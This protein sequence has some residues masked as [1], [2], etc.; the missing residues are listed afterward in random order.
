MFAYVFKIITN[1]MCTGKDLALLSTA[2][3]RL[4]KPNLN[5]GNLLSNASL[6][7]FSQFCLGIVLTG[8]NFADGTMGLAWPASATNSGGFCETRQFSPTYNQY[9]SFNS[10]I[11]TV[12]SYNTRVINPISQITLAHEVGH[13]FGS[14]H[15]TT[16][17]CAPGDSNGG[18]YIMYYAAVTSAEPN[19]RNFSQCSKDTMGP[20]MFLLASQPKFCF[21]TPNSTTCGNMIVE[22]GEQCDCGFTTDCTDKCCYPADYVDPTKRCKLTPSSKCRYIQ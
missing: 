7:D 10:A 6:D 13:G 19:N 2:D 16:K 12:M 3:Q 5:A 21:V 17:A 15:D 4:C 1:S 11:V 14:M 8:R 18:N 20:L 22:S 9:M